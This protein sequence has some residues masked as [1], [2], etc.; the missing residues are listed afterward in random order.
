MPAFRLCRLRF[1]LAAMAALSC[2]GQSDRGTIT[3]RIVDPTDSVVAGAAVT[4]LNQNTGVRTVTRTNEAGNYSVRELPF[5]KY[6]ISVEATGFRKY[7]RKDVEVA[8]G[9]TLN[10]DFKLDL[11]QI[12]QTVEVEAATPVLENGTS[13]LGTVL[14]QK[15]VQD[16][17]LSVSGNMRNPESFALLAPGVTGDVTNTQ[18]NGSQSRAKE[19][20]VDG[21][22]STSPE[23]GGLLFTYPSVESIGEFKLASAAFTAEYGKTGGG[24]EIFT[25]RS[26]TNQYHGTA[27]EYL[28]NDKLDARGFI[29]QKTPVNRQNEFGAS[30][31]GPVILPKYHGRNKTFFFFVYD[32]FRYR[33]GATNNVSTV[34]TL[35]VRSGDFSGLT[36][37]GVP[38]VIYDP[39]TTRLDASGNITR[40]P[41]L[42]NMIPKD[43]MSKVSLA[44][45]ALFPLPNTSQTTGNY[46]QVGSL[47]FDR[48]VYTV[49]FDHAFSDRSHLSFFF[50]DNEQTSIAPEVIAG[51]MSP[52]L[53]EIRPSRWLR[54]NH[55]YLITPSTV[56]NFRGGY[57]RDPQIWRRVTAGNGFLQ[58]TGLMG[59]NPPGNVVPRIQFSDTFS[60][61]ADE[62]KNIGRQVNNTLQFA[63][64]VSQLRG[65]HNLKFGIDMR[66]MQTNGA[67]TQNQQGTFG[68]NSNE[69][70]LPTA[71]GRGTSGNP[72]ASFLLGA[73][74]T[75]SYNGLFVVPANRYRYIAA[76]FQDD[77]KVTRKLTINAGLRWDLY[78]P[79]QEAHNNFAS[80]DPSIPNPGAGGRLGAVAFLGDGPGKI[81]GRSSFA[82]TYYKNFGPRLGFAYQLFKNTVLRGGYGIYY[83][84][85]NATAGLRSSQNF[86]YG[87]NASPSYASSDAGVTPAFYWDNGFPAVKRPTID[88]T[89]QN[90]N[91]VNM[92]GK[93]DGRPPY[94]QNA[95]F[96]VQQ[97]LAARMVVEA[98]YVGVKG[99]RL[100]NNLISLN[101]LDPVYLALGSTLTQNINSAAAAKAG[102][103]APYPGFTGSVAQAL[104]PY[105]Q[106]LN[107]V[108]IANPNGNSTYHALQTKL[109]NRFSHGLTLLVAYTWSKSISDGNVMAGGGPAG[110]DYYNRRLEKSLSTDDVPQNLSI[111]Y[112]YEL[113]FGAGKHFAKSGI[114]AKIAG[115][116]QLSGVQQYQSGKPVTLTANNTLPIF[117]GALRPDVV[118]GVPHQLDHPDPLN[119]PWFN[120]NA[121]AVPQTFHLGN[122]SRSYTDM[123]AQN[124]YSENF[125]LLRRFR[126]NERATVSFRGEFFNAFN[127]VVFAAPASNISA[128]NF[129]RVSSQANNPRQGQV[130]LRVD[131]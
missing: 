44:M 81:S 80:F 55:D 110:E 76:F 30:F 46:F 68:Y 59:V 123:R 71:A 130:S 5:G 15:Q 58:Q 13:E 118:A 96:S 45:L 83:A 103:T 102:I 29:A 128:S 16:L 6:E 104:R 22:G 98:A 31:G 48:N 60:N 74:D 97:L 9:Q 62:V 129:G 95:Q 35:K 40:D 21:V 28:R 124:L 69:T 32:G 125:G 61:W 65:N 117:N 116:W 14:D 126:L 77:W 73:V 111:A 20:L 26:G 87:L 53:Q 88:P 63:D 114:A 90:G 72:F 50:Y 4:V 84:Q 115:G 75:A 89:V 91:N 107:I 67:D 24:F 109:T 57:T 54:L 2:W 38:L 11:G 39:T 100:G 34:P 131:F 108:E 121:F 94:S 92:I 37:G 79:R 120:R 113:P 86:V 105:P 56:N 82:D 12:E 19:V 43:K 1:V 42:N 51:A 18:I 25:T 85:G 93:G 127:R 10:L 64:T 106:Y 122:A 47:V 17:P 7:I 36:K 8:L 99:T 78:I 41:F 101:Q 23:S 33:A 66:W 112:T 27:F 119:D 49:K 70:A 3:G 52:A